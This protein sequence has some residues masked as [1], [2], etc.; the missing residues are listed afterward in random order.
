MT[1]CGGAGLVPGRRPVFASVSAHGLRPLAG[2]AAPNAPPARASRDG[3]CQLRGG[4]EQRPGR[5][6][7]AAQGRDDIP[8]LH[9]GVE[10]PGIGNTPDGD[11]R[12]WQLR[13]HHGLRKTGAGEGICQRV[14]RPPPPG[15]GE[16]DRCVCVDRCG[17]VP[18]GL[19]ETVT[20]TGQVGS[21]Q[22][23]RL[24]I[25]GSERQLV[26]P[27]AIWNHTSI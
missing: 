13:R 1:P 24:F 26:Q 25:R 3:K 6:V 7:A 23:S 16:R 4:G 18:D 15:Q 20:R 10:Q 9:D 19:R 2:R 5:R 11:R 8:G 17:A 22:A 12:G 27:P 21:R 14:G